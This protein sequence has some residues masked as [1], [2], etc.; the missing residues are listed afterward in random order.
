MQRSRIFVILTIVTLTAGQAFAQAPGYLGKRL[1]VEAGGGLG[2]NVLDYNSQN[3][4]GN[5]FVPEADLSVNWVSGR[6]AYLSLQGSYQQSY[7]DISSLYQFPGNPTW[8][9][10]TYKRTVSFGMFSTSRR[11]F[12]A[13]LAPN[14]RYLG[15]RISFTQAGG[16]P[17]RHADSGERLDDVVK[18][19]YNIIYTNPYLEYLSLGMSFGNRIVFGDRYT[20]R[21][22]IDLDFRVRTLRTESD[23]ERIGTRQSG[24]YAYS[25]SDLLAE[26]ALSFH[27]AIGLGALLF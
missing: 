12:G 14:G 19:A 4:I 5:I 8:R 24:V 9:F 21:Y 2:L 18:A 10:R 22:G 15:Y 13:F 11:R 3:S 25:K 6:H 17:I 16:F 27:F 23:F 1:F 20:L 7:E 26:N